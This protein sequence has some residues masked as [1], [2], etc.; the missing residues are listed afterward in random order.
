[1]DLS[2]LTIP[3]TL[4]YVDN[5]LN[6]KSVSPQS[7]VAFRVIGEIDLP[8]L[9]EALQRV[10]LLNENLHTIYVFQQGK[11]IGLPDKNVICP[12]IRV[13]AEKEDIDEEMA[14]LN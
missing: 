3:Q 6:P 11:V 1:M 14:G 12:V 2:D 7:S 9:E 4:F 5:K 13:I 10:V 8:R